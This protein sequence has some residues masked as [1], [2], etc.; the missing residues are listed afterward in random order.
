M[1]KAIM[2]GYVLVGSAKTVHDY[3]GSVGN[4][5]V[6]ACPIQSGNYNRFHKWIAL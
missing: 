2:S 4:R 3:E 6:P 1:L 5:G